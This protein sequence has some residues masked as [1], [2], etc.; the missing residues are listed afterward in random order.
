MRMFSAILAGLVTGLLIYFLAVLAS[1]KAAFFVFLFG[2]VVF[3]YVF[4][5]GAESAG[6]VWS[7]ACLVAGVE[8]V[9]IPLASWLLPLFRGAKAVQAA[10]QGAY[11]AGQSFGSTLGGGMINALA[12]Y[13]GFLIGFILL[14]AAYYSMRP[15]RRN[16]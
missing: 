11:A 8:C 14:A 15:A 5:R 7:R 2:W 6:R 13:I 4:Y 3:A 12:G 16:R 10:K 9:A 1:V